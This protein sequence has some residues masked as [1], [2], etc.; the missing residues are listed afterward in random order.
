MHLVNYLLVPLVPL[1]LGQGFLGPSTE[2][3]MLGLALC[4]Q[5]SPRPAQQPGIYLP[6]AATMLSQPHLC[7]T[8][9]GTKPGQC[10]FRADPGITQAPLGPCHTT[11]FLAAN[12]LMCRDGD[13]L[14]Q[15]WVIC[16]SP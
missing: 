14:L 5:R 10:V 3:F 2:V 7:H 13:R 6:S 11:W 15:T 16:C 4:W 8:R 9:A 12:H 1:A